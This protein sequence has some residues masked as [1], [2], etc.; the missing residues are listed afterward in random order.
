[1]TSIQQGFRQ[2]SA[3]HVLWIRGLAYSS[4]LASSITSGGRPS[5]PLRAAG[6]PGDHSTTVSSG[7]AMT[8]RPSHSLMN[9]ICSMISALRFQGMIIT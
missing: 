1:M 2:R 7:M 5:R 9:D 3:F 8:N 4:S 6:L